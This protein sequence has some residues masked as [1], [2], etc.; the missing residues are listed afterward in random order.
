MTYK[1]EKSGTMLGENSLLA[2]CVTTVFC[3]FMVTMFFLIS[4]EED[5]NFKLRL[6]QV[7]LAQMQY[8]VGY[9]SKEMSLGE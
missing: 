6:E 8:S 2:I 3:V 1:N 7:K 5:R 9:A 4:L